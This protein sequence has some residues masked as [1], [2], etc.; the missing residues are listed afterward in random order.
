M[1]ETLAHSRCL[2]SVEG[3]GPTVKWAKS[4]GENARDE[5]ADFE[6]RL[7][8]CHRLVFHVAHAVLRDRAD[9]E[10]IVQDTFFRAYRKLY[11]L[12]EPQKFRAWVAR[13]GYRLALNRYRTTKR[14]RHRDTSWFQVSA[15]PPANIEAALEQRQ[16]QRRL[17]DEIDRLPKKLR[18]VLLLSAVQELD[19]RD[20]AIVLRIPEGTVR[21]RLHLARK[22]LLQVFADE[23][24]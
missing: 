23:I 5:A 18:A 1:S 9:A 12:R 7:R 14:A 24:L 15:P 6:Q 4:A 19:T 22:A 10:E 13:M 16:F 8:E 3:T 21:S 17:R 11:S 20:V 2:F